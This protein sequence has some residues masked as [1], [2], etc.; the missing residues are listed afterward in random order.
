MYLRLCLLRSR[1]R[2]I[3]YSAFAISLT[4]LAT[5][6]VAL[7]PHGDRFLWTRASTAAQATQYWRNGSNAA[8]EAMLFLLLFVAG[9]LGASVLGDNRARGTDSFLFAR[10]KRRSYFVWQGWAA[11]ILG[12]AITAAIAVVTCAVVLAAETGTFEPARLLGHAVLVLIAASVVLSASAALAA[13]RLN[14]ND[15]YQLAAGL[16]LVYFVAGFIRS[17]EFHEEARLVSTLH[18]VA[19]DSISIALFAGLAAVCLILPMVAQFALARR[20]V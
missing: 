1:V 15:A 3:I 13:A 18:W 12:L 4:L 20:D 11:A 19:A 7:V 6:P 5:L 17:T 16:L 2:L 14:A 10:P 9:D 8:L